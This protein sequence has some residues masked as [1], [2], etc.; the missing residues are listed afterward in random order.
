MNWK[1][2]VFDN[3]T[4]LEAIVEEQLG[5][6]ISLLGNRLSEF[7]S[8]K[9]SLI[10]FFI[11]TFKIHIISLNC[12]IF[13]QHCL[14]DQ[15]SHQVHHLRHLLWDCWIH[16]DVLQQ[17]HYLNHL[18]YSEAT[19]L[20]QKLLSLQ[21]LKSSRLINKHM[22]IFS[23]PLISLAGG[24]VYHNYSFVNVEIKLLIIIILVTNMYHLSLSRKFLER[25]KVCIF[26]LKEVWSASP[27]H[28]HH[29]LCHLQILFY[30]DWTRSSDTGLCS[31]ATLMSTSP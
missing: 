22:T 4:S 19:L 5:Q 20:S 17:T 7:A 24:R 16:E 8:F 23:I 3:F 18:S 27:K 30:A 25:F 28:H 31:K 10:S 14:E 2:K 29:N 26:H 11:L 13:V 15:V 6:P 1:R 12:I 21:L 9:L